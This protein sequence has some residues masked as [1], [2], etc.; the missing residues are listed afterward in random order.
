M[1]INKTSEI[2]EWKMEL[3]EER[4]KIAKLYEMGLIDS[5]GDTIF[6]NTIRQQRNY[7][8]KG[9]ICKFKD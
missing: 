6:V 1:I 7:Q 2:W 9:N 5:A 8:Q 3:L 4:T